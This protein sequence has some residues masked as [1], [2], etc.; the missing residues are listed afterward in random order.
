MTAY[1]LIRDIRVPID[2]DEGDLISLAARHLKIPPTQIR[3][4]RIARSSLDARKRNAIARLLHIEVSLDQQLNTTLPAHTIHLNQSTFTINKPS[5]LCANRTKYRQRVLIV[6][7]G[8]AGLFAALALAEAGIQ[9]TLVERG[10]GVEARMRDIGQLRSKGDLNPESN[11]CYGEGGAG[12]YTDG[13]L[14]TR[15]K[16]PYL[17]WVM[18][19]FVR[20]GAPPSILIDAHPHLGTDKLV[21][22]IRSFRDH[23]IAN[24]VEIR[25]QTR[26]DQLLLRNQQAVG[27]QCGADQIEADHVILAIGH[28]ARD[29]FEN[30]SRQGVHF[31]AKSF[32]VGLRAEHPQSLVNRAQFGKL[33]S[34]PKLGAAEY[35]LACQTQFHGVTRGVYSFCMCPGGFIVPTPTEPRHMVVNGMSNA[36]RS[37]RYAN[38]GIVVQVEPSDLAQNGYATN[39]LMGIQFQRDLEAAAFQATQTAYAAPAMRISDFM[40]RRASGSLAGTDFRPAVEAHDLWSILPHWILERL[41]AGLDQF[42]RRVK[43][44]TSSEGNL[45][46]V[47][48]RSSSPVRIARRPDFQSAHLDRLYPVGEGAGYA[49]GIVSAAV[50]GLRAAEAI[51][52]SAT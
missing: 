2:Q 27:V 19:Q 20:F 11:V 5:G 49:G 15:I 9:T 50:D 38:S 24:G 23:L 51:I 43:G 26:V 40:S 18:A 25:F 4:A 33:A 32:A 46:A 48:S 37:A 30:L 8:P 42:G 10:K 47:E 16:S 35:R 52:Q 44:Y 28:S 13:K 39:P 22:I 29:T 3:A 21:R 6:G 7:S 45:L 31:E 34:H 1:Y 12:T 41:A 17:R 14:Y 36:N